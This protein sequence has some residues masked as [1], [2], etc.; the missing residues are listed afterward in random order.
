MGLSHIEI[1]TLIGLKRN[2]VRKHIRA[3][4]GCGL[5][6]PPKNLSVMRQGVLCMN[7]GVEACHE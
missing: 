4:E 1:G 5:L 2:S 6:E 7:D 3:M